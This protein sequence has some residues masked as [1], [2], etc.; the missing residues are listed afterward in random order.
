MG[1]LKLFDAVRKPCESCHAPANVLDL[2]FR[3]TDESGDPAIGIECTPNLLQEPSGVTPVR[4]QDDVALGIDCVSCHVSA[5]G[6]LGPGR[7][8]S[9]VHET[10]ADSRF[11]DAGRTSE[12]VCRTCH[13]TTVDVWKHTELAR[14]G[15]TCLDCHMPIVEA[16]SVTGG[17]ARARRSHRFPGDKDAAMLRGAINA[18]LEIA[19]DRTA[20]FRIVND[21]VG[22]PLPSG[23]NFLVVELRARDESGKVVAETKRAFGRDEPLLLDFWPFNADRR[24]QPGGH[25][26][27][28]LPLPAGNGRV[29]ALVRY[30]DWI[31]VSRVVATMEKPY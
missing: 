18:S 2:A 5:R 7:T 8:S 17:P 16:P 1:Y 24:I 25:E 9:S 21:R 12:T 10:T 19:G 31:K 30:H 11:L 26:E 13:R 22:H 14:R 29:E 27:L 4:R 15:T 23:A 28:S 6:I 3:A 20:R